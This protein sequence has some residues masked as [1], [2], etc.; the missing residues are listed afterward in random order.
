VARALTVARVQTIEIALNWRWV[1]LV[2][3]GTWLLAHDLLPARFPTWGLSATW[4]T[5]GAAVMAGEAALLLHE[6]SHA[7]VAKCYG[8]RV[9]RIVFHGFLA[10]TIVNDDSTR[11]GHT[12]R[13][14]LAG[15]ATNLLLAVVVAGLRVALSSHGPLDAFL[16]MLLLGNAAAAGLSLI[17]LGKSD[18]ARALHA[19]R[20]PSVGSEVEV[21]GQ[22]QDQND[23]DE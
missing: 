15:P 3:L 10:E 5:A 21:G 16:L 1:P 11:P 23:Q 7:L 14:A 19:L 2:M 4:I 18:G 17:P 8:Q 20:A 9:E 12:V 6:L 13:I 22:R